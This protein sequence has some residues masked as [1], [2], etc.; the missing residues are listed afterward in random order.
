M[1]LAELLSKHG[2]PHYLKVDIE[3]SDI[4]CLE[5]LQDCP[6]RPAY[7]SIE[8]SKNDFREVA[9]EF[10]LL[11]NAGYVD[12]QAVQ[13]QNIAVQAPPCPA[14][15]GLYVPY[16]FVRGASG[17]FG[18]ELP[19]PWKSRQQALRQYQRIFLA[20]RW[21]GEEAWLRRHFLTAAALGTMSRLT[22][23]PLSGWY[24]THARH[25]SAAAGELS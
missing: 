2:V 13:Q 16:R 6:T 5:A 18:R 21:F 23:R 9:A 11:E 10:D 4:Y 22:G 20:Y 12:F 15:E 7:V 1:C 24:D 14:R 3:G 19:G 17:L 25:R 8:S